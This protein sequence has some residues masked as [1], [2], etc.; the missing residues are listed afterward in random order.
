LLLLTFIL[1]WLALI[2]TRSGPEVAAGV[3]TAVAAVWWVAAARSRG[4]LASG[5]PALPPLRALASVP[6][7]L[8]VES[9]LVAVSTLLALV[10]RSPHGSLKENALP[11]EP[12]ERGPVYDGL[13]TL[14]QSFT[15]NEYV[16]AIDENRQV[17][18]VHELV[19]KREG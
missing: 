6:S 8:G 10:A 11:S 14:V 15:P 2:S 12:P 18:V 19:A 16:L 3:L 7:K 5:G 1:I 9:Y 13:Y 17:A 4:I